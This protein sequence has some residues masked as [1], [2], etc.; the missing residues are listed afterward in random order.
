M[1]YKPTIGLE[2]HAELSTKTKMFCACKND[3]DEKTPN[4]NICPVCMGHPGTLPVMNKEAVKNVLKVGLAINGKL[5]LEFSE[6]DRKNYFYPDIP[7]AYQI[8]QYKFPL[9]SEGE[10]AGVKIERIHLEEDTAKSSHDK[11]DYSLVDFNRAGVPLMELVT[12]P[13]IHSGEEIVK[14]GEELQ[15]TLQY[16]G[17][18]EANMEKGEMRLEVNIS[19]SKEEGVLGTKVEVKN[20]NSFRAAK[21]AAEYEEKRQIGLLEKGEK[22]KQE[23][24]GWDEKTQTTFSQRSKEDSHDYRYFPDPDLPK[25]RLKDLPEFSIEALKKDLKETPEQK[26]NRYAE[27]YGLKDADVAFYI[28]NPALGNLFEQA[29][30]NIKDKRN[31]QLLS[32]YIVSDIAGLG[33]KGLS[34][35]PK[36]LAD[37]IEMAVGGQVSSRG[38]KDVILK[39]SETEEDPRVIAEREGLIQKNDEGELLKVVESVILANP[40]VVADYK[41]GKIALIQFFVGQAMK[42]TKGSGNPQVLKALFEKSLTN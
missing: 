5:A 9:V 39:M 25:L 28:G 35:N 30:L 16:L 19:V 12:K 36:H 41:S 38:V 3:T 34:L 14:F 10:L 13:V 27:D 1:S 29:I 20:I 8:S 26:R 32:N 40:T 37:L 17:V 4:V 6:F 21:S 23:T 22:I 42:E 7:K 24:R 31:F 33:E 15:K 18:A 11:G 2:I